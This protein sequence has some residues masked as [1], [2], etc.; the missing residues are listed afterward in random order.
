M[1]RQNQGRPLLICG[2]LFPVPQ[3]LKLAR[4]VHAAAGWRP[5]IV[6][7]RLPDMC[8]VITYAEHIGQDTAALLK[9]HGVT[10]LDLLAYSMGGVAALYLI[11]KLGWHDR[12][13][14]LV[15]YGS[16]FGGSPL[17]PYT[18][19]TGT[20]AGC[21]QQLAPNS[22]LLLDLASAGSS[23]DPPIVSVAGTRDRIVPPAAT[24]L[25]GATNVLLP[26][27]HTSFLIDRRLHEYLAQLPR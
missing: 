2:G 27:D 9:R 12:V 26:F 11:R 21:A 24:R 25:S 8:D 15:C 4:D 19:L 5:S 6:E 16:P 13:A 10:K 22:P 1:A 20:F 7:W 14:S 18:K 3:P 17:A 23:A